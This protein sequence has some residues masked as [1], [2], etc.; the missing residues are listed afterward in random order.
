LGELLLI[1]IASML[2]SAVLWD[3]FRKIR[4]SASCR[5]LLALAADQLVHFVSSESLFVLVMCIPFRALA[6]T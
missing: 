3:S 2:L 4:R 5:S 6:I 1:V